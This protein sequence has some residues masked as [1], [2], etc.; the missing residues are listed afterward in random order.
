MNA[1]V[2]TASD[3]HP[4]TRAAI[5][6][7]LALGK[8]NRIAVGIV[9]GGARFVFGDT[10]GRYD[11]GSL[12]KTLTAHLV[13]ALAEQGALSLDAEVSEYLP[14]PR[15]HYPTLRAL[16][17]HTAGY[18]HLTP[19]GITL[20]GLL[21]GRYAKR[22]PYSRATDAAVLDAL[23]HRRARGGR[24]GYSDFAYAVLA[25]AVEAVT[26]VPFYETLTD[27]ARERL[28]LSDIRLR[29]ETDQEPIAAQGDKILPFWKWGR[30]NPYLAA[31]GFTTDLFDM[32][33]YLETELVS[34]EPYI[35]EAQAV[36]P[37]S[38]SERRSIAS[39]LGWHTYR[40]S[41]LLWQIGGVGTF[42]TALLFSRP[43]GIG[44]AVL[45]NARG[46]RSANVRY[47]ANMLYGDLKRRKMRL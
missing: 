33:S 45:G 1:A 25:L 9:C 16:L 20:P 22:N 24:Y 44:V 17:S 4:K 23:G 26:G 29:D 11:M 31:G 32:L 46:A 21:F 6:A 13:L 41:S 5:E 37:A 7:Y 35:T 10:E 8:R 18:G 47:I 36:E 12:S 30:E 43:R 38:L 42:R 2:L 28:G 19:L 27:F 40:G 39:A 15:G 34:G 14:L 3:L